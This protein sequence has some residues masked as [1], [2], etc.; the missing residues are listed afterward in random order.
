MSA[1]FSRK[2]NSHKGR[3]FFAFTCNRLREMSVAV[4]VIEQA[5]TTLVHNVGRPEGQNAVST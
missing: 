4:T 2:T 3:P 1:A 5:M